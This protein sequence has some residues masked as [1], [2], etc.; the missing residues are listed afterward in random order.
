MDHYP[1]VKWHDEVKQS[2]SFDQFLNSKFPNYHKTLSF[3]PFL[4]SF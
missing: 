2:L 3:C 4:L 1:V